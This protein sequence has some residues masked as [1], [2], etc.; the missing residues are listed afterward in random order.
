[1]QRKFII[2]VLPFGADNVV[3]CVDSLSIVD[4]MQTMRRDVEYTR[5]YSVCTPLTPLTTRCILQ[6]SVL[7]KQEPRS[8]AAAWPLLQSGLTVEGI[9]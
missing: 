4:F 3:Q 9:L 7:T 8:R 2:L 1:M 6:R 5:G